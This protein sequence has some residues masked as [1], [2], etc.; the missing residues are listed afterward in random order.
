VNSFSQLCTDETQVSTAVSTLSWMTA[1]WLVK[2]R[3]SVLGII[4]G[5]VAGLVAITPAAGCVDCTGA[6]FIG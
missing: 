3:P 1:E 6:F 4:S 2:K 5:T